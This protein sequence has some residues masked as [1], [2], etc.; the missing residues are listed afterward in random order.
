MKRLSLMY[1]PFGSSGASMEYCFWIKSCQKVSHYLI[2]SAIIS[3]ISLAQNYASPFSTAE[4]ECSDHSSHLPGLASVRDG[5]LES[6]LE[7]E[8]S[9]WIDAWIERG[10]WMWHSTDQT[11]WQDQGCFRIGQPSSFQKH[12]RF[13][14]P[15]N[16]DLIE[17]LEHCNRNNFTFSAMSMSGIKYYY[18]FK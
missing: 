13:V 4:N 9:T 2:L 11:I 16:L 6:Q 12:F 18:K 1:Y 10:P 8:Q 15:I 3:G 17:C 7:L 5:S 14:Q